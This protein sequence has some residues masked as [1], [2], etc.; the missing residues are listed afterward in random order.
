MSGRTL[1]ADTSSTAGKRN[2][3]IMLPP[4]YE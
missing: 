4:S 1:Q 3:K 2:R